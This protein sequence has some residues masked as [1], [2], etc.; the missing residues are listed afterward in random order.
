[1]LIYNIGKLI[2]GDL[3]KPISSETSI[4]IEDGYFVEIG[5]TRKDA[6]I[7]INANGLM[8]T[9]GLIDG[10]VHPTIGDFSSAQNSTSWVTHYLHGGITR[11]V[12]AGELHYPGLPFD[13][14]D[15]EL[16]KGLARLTKNCY[17]RER[18]SGVKIDAGTLILIPG[19]KEEDFEEMAAIGSKCVKFIFYPY[20]KIQG[21]DERY[22]RWAK[23]KGLVVKIHSGGV[24]RS[25]KSIPAGADLILRLKPDI[26]GHINGGP[27]PMAHRD[28]DRIIEESNCWLEI[29]YSGNY[30][31]TLYVIRK[32]L[33]VGC[34][35]RIC[36]GT[37]TPGGTG[38]TPRGIL[39]TM[40]LLSSLGGV[41]PEDAI[42]LATGNVAMA[43][44]LDSGWIQS[45][46]PADFVIMGKI[47][48]CDAENELEV[49][50]IGDLLGIS[51][52]VIDGK[53]VIRD[54]SFQT[55]PP[56]KKAFIEKED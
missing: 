48:G 51:M 42:C 3:R 27:I 31:T 14:P 49:L 9:P 5:S 54:R 28:I 38:I 19:L 12:S 21:E 52:V 26:V 55:P 10:H 41:Q 23:E 46:K 17:D 2:T 53:I 47:Q 39:R 13:K 11:M 56:E 1:M 44:N 22:V 29:T 45:G 6:N 20:G 33:E 43:H 37:D 18:P 34:L 25:G 50:K 4:Y 16:F 7:I 35:S 36:L 15:P 40:A 24:S 32:A 8:V 30:K